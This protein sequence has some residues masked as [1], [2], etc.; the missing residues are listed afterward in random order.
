MVQLRCR[1]CAV[2]FEAHRRDQKYCSKLCANRAF[3][4]RRKADGRLKDYR[5]R[6]AGQR[7]EWL[8]KARADRRYH[9]AR[10][11]TMCGSEFT[12]KRHASTRTCSRICKA[13][14]LR[15]G[16]WP[17]S[18]VPWRQ[19]PDCD[20]WRI[21]R[22]GGGDRCSGCHRRSRARVW[23][24]GFCVSCGDA[25]T[26]IDQNTARYC[27]TTCAKRESKARRRA[28]EAGAK[29]TPGRRHRVYE[30]DDWTCRICGDPVN[31][32]AV[33]PELD[34]PVIDHILPLAVGG[35]HCEDNWQTAHF[36][37]NSV[38]QDQ[39]GFDFAA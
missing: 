9:E 1:Q 23:I 14:L 28:R 8:R 15:G 30:R 38:K 3:N 16:S 37:C 35:A 2:P 6:T 22:D 5:K 32:G 13:A 4:A 18:R 7:N 24:S 19:C 33:V 36:Y 12:C 17:A 10:T 26:V 27:S 21:D 34:A 29:I 20:G 11:C 25:F 31:R 39:V